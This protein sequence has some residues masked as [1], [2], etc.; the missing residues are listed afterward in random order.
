MSVTLEDLQEEI[1]RGGT[2]STYQNGENQWGSKKSPEIE[3]YN[4]MIKNHMSIIKQLT[5]LL[6]PTEPKKEK[7]EPDEFEKLLKR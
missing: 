4:A 1:N 5:E 7:K 3:I 6:P 2:V